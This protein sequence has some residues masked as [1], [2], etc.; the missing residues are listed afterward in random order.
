MGLVHVGWCVY[1]DHG[2]C[3]GWNGGSHSPHPKSGE[4]PSDSTNWSSNENTGKAG[5]AEEKLPH[6]EPT[7]YYESGKMTVSVCGCF[8]TKSLFWPVFDKILWGL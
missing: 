2:V 3:V 7:N 6:P 1:N 8:K 5:W 4:Y